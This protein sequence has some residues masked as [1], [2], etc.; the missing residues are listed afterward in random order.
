M[1]LRLCMPMCKRVINTDISED[2]II[3]D[4]YPEIRRVLCVR[5]N[6]LPPAK[7][8]SGNKI[9]INGVV[10]YILIYVSA[11]GMLCSAPLSAEYSFSVPLDNSNEFELSEGVN[12]MARSIAESS[13]VRVGGPRK[14]QIRSHIRSNVNAWG[15]MPYSESIEGIEDA[16]SIQRL[17]AE[18]SCAEMLCENSDIVTVSDEYRLPSAESRIAVADSVAIVHSS[19]VEGEMI[20]ASGEVIVGMLVI[21]PDGK[22]EKIVRKIPFEAESDLDGI[23]MDGENRL[24][25]N[26]NITELNINVEEDNVFI[27][28][29][30]VLEICMIQNR[31]IIYTCDA[32]STEQT[33]ATDMKTFSLPSVIENRSVEI[34]QSERMALSELNFA[35][36]SEIIDVYGSATVGE[37]ALEEDRYVIRGNCKYNIICFKDGEYSHCEVR[38]PFKYECEGKEEIESFD[39]SAQI[40]SCKVRQDGELLGVDAELMLSYNI[41][42][43][44]D[45]Q[46][47]EKITFFD[48]NEASHG[49][50]TVCYVGN[51]ESAWDIAKRYSVRECDIKGDPATDRYVVIER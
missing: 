10:D 6:M 29:N 40:I 23:D 5:E 48:M 50:W 13:T 8:V 44:S 20:Y 24:R 35:E 3:P 11:N 2:I 1:D 47:L 45:T 27:E 28:A 36:G 43:R 17:E 39:E 34:S 19:R 38:V 22:S 41:M 4:Y 37:V 51:G 30:L 21:T 49:E 32:Y 42:C 16:S 31:S 9:D 12:I 15:K 25:I 46:M 7:F 14:L 33:S 26:G 18:G